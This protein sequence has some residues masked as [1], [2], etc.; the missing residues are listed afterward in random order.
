MQ[1]GKNQSWPLQKHCASNPHWHHVCLNHCYSNGITSH[2]H[3][4]MWG[5]RTVVCENRIALGKCAYNHLAFSSPDEAPLPHQQ[6]APF[7]E[8]TQKADC[9]VIAMAPN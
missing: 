6:S 7:D 4:K 3:F 8:D 1:N 5:T 9:R 2:A